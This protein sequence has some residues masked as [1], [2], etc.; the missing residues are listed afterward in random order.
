[1]GQIIDIS[2]KIT[3]QLPVVKVTDEIVVTVNNR[4]S[5]ILNIQAM[6]KEQEKKAKKNDDKYD[7]IDFMNRTLTML[8][9]EKNVQAIE[10]LD[11]P[12]PEYKEL[13]EAVM[14]TATGAYGET[15]SK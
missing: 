10:E 11:L 3:N 14:N 1:M 7:E 8:I 4:K 6:I 9:G 13:Y 15:P 2:S 5:T 12:F